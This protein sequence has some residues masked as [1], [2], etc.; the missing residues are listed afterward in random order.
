LPS[1]LSPIAGCFRGG[2]AAARLG[3]TLAAS[4][5]G[6]KAKY[7]APGLPAACS[8]TSRRSRDQSPSSRRRSPPRGS[9]VRAT[10][11]PDP[12]RKAFQSAFMCGSDHA[13]G[14]KQ[15]RTSGRL[16]A[17]CIPRLSVSP[18]REAASVRA[19]VLEQVRRPIAA[20]APRPTC[21]PV[22]SSSRHG[23]FHQPPVRQHRDQSRG[24]KAATG[25]RTPK[26]RRAGGIAFAPTTKGCTATQAA[27]RKKSLKPFSPAPICR[28]QCGWQLRRASEVH[29][30]YL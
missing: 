20:F 24:Q 6:T 14:R 26:R 15:A 2:F 8:R 17:R 13:S 25:R 28:V 10:A 11:L 4:Q 1:R 12:A 7:P 9:P 30:G 29:G 19:S 5:T 23:P 27:R 16:A 22:N 3:P 18:T 21:R